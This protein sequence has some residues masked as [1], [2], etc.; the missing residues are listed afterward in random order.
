MENF[1]EYMQ[2]KINSSFFFEKEMNEAILSLYQKGLIEVD[3]RDGEPLISIS[4]LGESAYASLILH[5][6]APMGEA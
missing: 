6:M 1:E 4:K 5:Y 2:M 3:M